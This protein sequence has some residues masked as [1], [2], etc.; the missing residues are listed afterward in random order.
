MGQLTLGILTPTTIT[1]LEMTE[2][3][4]LTVHPP[5]NSGQL[6][7]MRASPIGTDFYR[8][9][10]DQVGKPYKWFSRTL[11]DDEALAAILDDPQVEVFVLYHGGVPA[12]YFELDFRQAGDCEILFIGLTQQNIGKGLGSFLMASALQRAWDGQ[13]GGRKTQKVH[14]Q[15]CTLDHPSAL[16]F[17]QKMGFVP[18]SQEE[19][20]L[21]IPDHFFED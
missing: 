9:L 7:L 11:I 18:F 5:S 20:E 15:T 6:A 4:L 14:L 10:F 19:A 8:F 16:S 3:P 12:G 21:D 13:E 1:Y 17:Y 2:E